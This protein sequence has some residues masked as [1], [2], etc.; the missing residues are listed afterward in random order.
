MERGEAAARRR[1]SLAADPFVC[2][3]LLTA[4]SPDLW[5]FDPGYVR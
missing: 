3:V 2:P 4:R 1:Q 5:L